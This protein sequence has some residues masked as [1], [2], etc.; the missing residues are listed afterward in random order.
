MR[1][2]LLSFNPKWF[3]KIM[4]GEKIYEYRSFFPEEEITAYMYVSTPVKQIIGKIHLG[5]R[6]DLKEWRERYK[7][8]KEVLQRIEYYMKKRRYAMPIISYQ[9]TT[10]LDLKDL[11]KNVNG[12]VVP[13]MYYY[14]DNREELLSY[15]EKNIK[16]TGKMVVNDFSGDTLDDICKIDY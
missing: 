13:Q 4:S 5:K 15:I 1:K 7:D 10:G 16:I 6:I 9:Q 3:N 11:R 2:M 14:L 12:F 8:N